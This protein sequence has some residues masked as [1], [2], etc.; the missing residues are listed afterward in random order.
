[1]SYILPNLPYTYDEFEPYFDK[2]TMEIHYT[3]HHQTY[4]NNINTAFKQLPEFA[5]FN[6]NT[7]VQQ[8]HKIPADLHTFVRNNAGGHL[9]HNLFWKGLK[10]NTVL[11]GALKTAI[12]HNFSNFDTFKD[13]FEKAATTLFGSGWIWLVMKNVSTL[14]ILST[15]N[16]DNPMMGEIISGVSGYPII[17]LDM[18]EHAYYLKYQN[19][20]HDY[21]KA[22]W[23]VVNWDE[24]EKRFSVKKNNYFI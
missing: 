3:K 10:K 8:L 5:S 16:Q 23:S 4:I 21:I 9:N 19:R 1:M 20:R 6:I 14:S 11:N 17:G 18:W 12:E 24:A 22:F 2:K 7:L 15:K 13:L